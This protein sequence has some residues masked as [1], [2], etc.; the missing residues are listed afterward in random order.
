[1][2]GGVYNEVGILFQD[3]H[4]EALLKW[5]DEHKDIAPERLALMAPVF[6]EDG[7]FSPIMK[8]VIER[9]GM[10]PD[11]QS[12]INSNL[13]SYGVTG[14]SVPLFEQRKRALQEYANYIDPAV[15][16]WANEMIKQTDKEIEYT[17]NYEAEM[18]K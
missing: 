11:V 6:G 17:R 5:C 9:Y 4:S 2:I 1:M 12:G 16:A 8:D 14:S 15:S 3:D 18:F 7:L 10:M 13:N